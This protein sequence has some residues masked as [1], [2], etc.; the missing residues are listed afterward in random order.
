M[1]YSDGTPLLQSGDVSQQLNQNHMPEETPIETPIEETPTEPTPQPTPEPTPEPT[2]QPTPELITLDISMVNTRESFELLA[3]LRGY[4]TEVRK[5]PEEMAGI[6]NP[7]LQDMVKPNPLS[8]VEWLHQHA[9][10][11][12]RREVENTLSAYYA[13]QAQEQ[14]DANLSA[15]RATVADAIK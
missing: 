9:K 8:K 14:A 7:S 5:T 1:Y 2:P 13:R 10:D 3:D 4:P 11:V 15:V 12:I 6:A